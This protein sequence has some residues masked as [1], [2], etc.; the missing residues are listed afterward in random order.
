[1]LLAAQKLITGDGQTV[2]P[3]GALLIEGKQIVDIGSLPELQRRYPNQTEITHYGDATLLPGLIDM[4]VHVGYWYN[5]RQR[6]IYD[7]HLV[8]LMAQNYAR[9]ALLSGVTTMRDVSSGNGVCQALVNGARL[10]YITIPRL[11]YVN[12]AI[13]ATGGHAYYA[14]DSVIEVDGEVEIRKAVRRQVKAGAQWIKVM[15]SHR[16]PG[17]SEF[18]L[19]ELRAAVDEAHRHLRKIAVHAGLQP[20]IEYCVEAGFD[21]IEHGTEISYEQ[22]QRMVAKGMAWT[23]TASV[24]HYSYQRLEAIRASGGGINPTAIQGESLRIYGAANA[25]FRQKLNDFAALGLT[26]VAGTDMISEDAPAAPVAAELKVFV[27]YGYTPVQAIAVGTSHGAKVLG[28]A[29]EIGLL[30][31]GAIADILVVQGDASR[32]ITALERVKKVYF[33]GELQV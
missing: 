17:I 8:A 28:L 5:R 30:A 27:E 7:P 12:Q 29:G 15:T 21:T 23:P 25:A 9:R 19:E 4:H 16:T 3:N 2:I 33:A 11:F 18:T 31:K 13:I 1:M 32:D 14:G 22:A 26:I 10:G 24:H 20:A 6:D